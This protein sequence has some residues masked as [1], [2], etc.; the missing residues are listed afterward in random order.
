MCNMLFTNQFICPPTS[1]F[2]SAEVYYIII[3]C[4]TCSSTKSLLKRLS[5]SYNIETVRSI[6]WVV[7]HELDAAA[8]YRE[9]GG[10]IEETGEIIIF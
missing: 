10:D 5:C 8:K 6:A 4:F 7:N 9:S 1:P 2:P 3:L